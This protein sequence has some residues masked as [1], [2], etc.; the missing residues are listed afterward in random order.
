MQEK[1]PK[2][3]KSTDPVVVIIDRRSERERDFSSAEIMKMVRKR[4]AKRLRRETG[5]G[6]KKTG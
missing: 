2:K 6:D 3:E 4:S 1:D 5:S